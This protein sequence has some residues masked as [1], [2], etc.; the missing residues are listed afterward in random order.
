HLLSCLETG[1]ATEALAGATPYLRL[2]GLAA[3][4]AYLAKGALASLVDSAPEA[5]LRIATARFFAEQLA[6]ETAALRIAVIDGAEAVLGF[7]PA[8]LAG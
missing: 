3:G 6:P 5:A 1:K 4:G 8:Q 7:D 2:F